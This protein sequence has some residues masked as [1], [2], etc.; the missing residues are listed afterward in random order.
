VRE[1]VRHH[2]R[3][4]RLFGR[5]DVTIFLD[6]DKTSKF[7]VIEGVL[8]ADS[9]H[10]ESRQRGNGVTERDVA[11]AHSHELVL[12]RVKECH[13]IVPYALYAPSTPIARP[14]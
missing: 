9:D 2:I 10:D 5:H 3:F 14:E 12:V 11:V 6:D 8:V 7:S 13:L 4:T 1:P